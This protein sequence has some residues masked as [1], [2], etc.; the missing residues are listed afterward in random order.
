VIE[1]QYTI[2]NIH[3]IFYGMHPVVYVFDKGI[4]GG[5]ETQLYKIDTVVSILFY[6]VSKRCCVDWPLIYPCRIHFVTKTLLILS[7]TGLI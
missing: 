6:Y 1:Q 3:F 7:T 2:S 4:L 5:F